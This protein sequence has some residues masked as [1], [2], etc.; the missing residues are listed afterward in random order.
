MFVSGR[1]VWSRLTDGTENL[2]D[3]RH[4]VTRNPTIVPTMDGARTA[5]RCG[6]DVTLTADE[7]TLSP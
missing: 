4:P 2:N 7:I 3:Q 1:E 5:G 6:P